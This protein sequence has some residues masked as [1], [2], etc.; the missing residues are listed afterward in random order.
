MDGFLRAY[1]IDTGEMLWRHEMPAGTQATP[2][3]YEVGGRQYVVLVTGITSG[4][5]AR[6]RRSD[7]VRAAATEQTRVPYP[8][9]GASVH[10]VQ[11]AAEKLMVC[12]AGRPG[13]SANPS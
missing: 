5:I 3:T 13:V 7:C 1:D 2:M 12:R 9:G 8:R 4:S 11:V 10:L 6:R